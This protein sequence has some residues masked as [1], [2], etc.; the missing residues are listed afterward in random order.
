[1]RRPW[2]NAPS[3]VLV[4]VLLCLLAAP[5][6]SGLN[7]TD[8]R[9]WSWTSAYLPFSYNHAVPSPMIV[10]SASL[11]I[12]VC[13]WTPRNIVVKFNGNVVATITSN[14]YP[15]TVSFALNPAWFVPGTVQSVLIDGEYSSHMHHSTLSVTYSV[16]TTPPT[17]GLEVLQGTLWPPNHKMVLAAKIAVTDD[18]DPAPEVTISVVTNQHANAEGDGNTE[19]DWEV[20]KV[21]DVWEVWLRAERAGPEEDRIYAISVTARDLWNNVATAFAQ[22]TVPHDQRKP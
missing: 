5:A 4:P 2:G 18:Q 7:H 13:Q 1:M 9:S 6:A 21:G 10:E 11:T 19:P 14:P 15:A 17:I 8:Y 16:D 12:L 20:K 3:L 22:V